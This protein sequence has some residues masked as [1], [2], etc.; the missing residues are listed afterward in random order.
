MLGKLRRGAIRVGLEVIQGLNTGEAL[1][2][3]NEKIPEGVKIRANIPYINRKGIPLAMDVFQPDGEEYN[4]VELPVIVNIHGGGLVTGDRKMAS[5]FAT[6]LAGK[7]YLVFAIEYRLAPRADVTEQFDDICAGMD[8]VGE[9]LLDYDV[10]YSRIF[11]TADSAGAFLAIYTAAMKTSVKLQDSIGHQPS[12]MIFKALGFTGGMFYTNRD[13]ILGALLSEQFYGSKKDDSKFLQYMNPEHP[14]IVNNLPPTFLVTSRGDFLNSYTIRY[15][16]VLKKAGRTTKMLYYPEKELYHTFNFMHPDYPQSM[17]AN[18]KMLAFFEEQAGITYERDKNS[19]EREQKIKDIERRIEKGVFENQR[20]WK[21]IRDINSV[22]EDNLDRL[23]LKDDSRG[24]TYRQMFR[25]WDRY[26]EVF[27]GLKINWKSHS[28]VGMPG[29]M[30][31]EAVFAFYGLDMTG[32]V[33]SLLPYGYMDK[34]EKLIEAVRAEEL[35]DLILT[36]SETTPGLLKKILDKK[37][38]LGL[39]NVILLHSDVCCPGAGSIQI[40][41]AA[42]NAAELRKLSGVSR[43]D[44]LMV[45]FEATPVIYGRLNDGGVIFHKKVS[46]E[47]AYVPVEYSDVEINTDV[48]GRGDLESMR[49]ANVLTGMSAD[50]SVSCVL[51]DQLQ[52][53]L[54]TGNCVVI[55]YRT[56][57]RKGFLKAAASHHVNVLYLYREQLRSMM[58]SKTLRDQ[59]LSGFDILW[60]LGKEMDEEELSELQSWFEKRGASLHIEQYRETDEG[61]SEDLFAGIMETSSCGTKA[62]AATYP[63]LMLPYTMNVR[64]DPKIRSNPLVWEDK[65]GNRHD[66]SK[67]IQK[68]LPA[69]MTARQNSKKSGKADSDQEADMMRNL[70]KILA[71]MFDPAD[72]DYYYEE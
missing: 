52:K 4:G 18:E 27:S 10:D 53:S 34:A 30:T 63:S 22:Y 35:T 67:I 71:V 25:N 20:L 3:V 68:L 13:D 65:N 26:A 50:L 24:Y 15:Q 60:V 47:D 36:D 39:R 56:G 58:S 40:K 51:K 72:T 14:E 37:E 48:F 32:A 29:A 44:E 19:K 59:D 61:Y 6:Y 16:K 46:G 55:T 8:L 49:M 1:G 28:R 11:M 62:A 33:I 12:R 21:T 54:Y 64:P 70:M 42:E 2:S 31:K 41:K 5:N 57:F 17:D 9:M 7:G 66:L 69:L 38:E 23:A 45:Q 43:M